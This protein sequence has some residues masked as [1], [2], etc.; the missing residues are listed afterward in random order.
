MWGPDPLLTPLGIAQA[1]DA[2][3]A[4]RSEIQHEL[5][6]PEVHYLSPLK[7][8]IDT[9]K[10]TFSPHRWADRRALILEVASSLLY[11]RILRT[12][13][14]LGPQHCREE[15]GVHTCDLRSSLS[16]LRSIYPPPTFEFEPGFTE[17]DP[18]WT[19]DV[20][21]SKEHIVQRALTVLDRAFEEDATC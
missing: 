19:S 9:W 13:D 8:A 10:T 18:L 5:P 16:H 7:R 2:H 3:E 6:E 20:R 4:W 17:E 11:S 12:A 1:V 21:E 15:Y 14:K